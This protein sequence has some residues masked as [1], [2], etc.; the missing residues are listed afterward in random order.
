MPNAEY[1]TF[2]ELEDAEQRLELIN[3]DGTRRLT[4]DELDP[5]LEVLERVSD[6]R[7]R[8]TLSKGRSHQPESIAEWRALEQEAR[9]V[10]RLYIQRLHTVGPHGIITELAQC[11][12][13]SR[14]HI[15]RIINKKSSGNVRRED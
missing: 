15:N 5:Y 6:T 2:E 9:R 14:V 13:H 12:Q 7:V 1:M 4:L 8:A 11:T 3:G 10:E